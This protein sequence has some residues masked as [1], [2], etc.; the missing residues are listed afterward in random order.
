MVGTLLA[1]SGGKILSGDP[2]FAVGDT[3]LG[4]TMYVAKMLKITPPKP[5]PR[6]H[7][8]VIVPMYSGNHS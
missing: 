5:T 4:L 7:I 2:G 1:I 3:L 8:P 6:L